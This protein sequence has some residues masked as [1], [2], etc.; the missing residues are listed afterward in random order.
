MKQVIVIGG[1][2]AGMMAAI[3][4]AKEGARVTLLEQNEKTGKKIFITGKGRCNLTNACEQEDFFSHVISN[5]KFLYSAFYQ[6]DNQSVIDFFENAGC[7]LKVERGDRVFPLSDHSSDVIAALNRQMEK[8][9]I[10]VCLHTKVKELLTTVESGNLE[11]AAEDV[12]GAQSQPKELHIMGV[13]LADGR[14][15]NADAVIVATGGKS[16]E[17]TG[18]T[19][20][21]YGFAEG[22]GHTVKEVKPALVPFT[23]K[24]SW[25]M[26]LQ[27][28]SLKNVAITLKS[29]KKKIYEGFGEMLFTHFGV[30]GPLILS[31]SSYYVKKFYGMPVQ[32]LIDLKPALTREQLDKRLLKDFGENKNRQF[33]NALDGLFPSKLIPIMIRLSGI[34][35]EKRVNEITR[36]ERS[37]LIECTKALALTVTGTRDFKEAIITQG[38]VH[39][40]EVNPSTMESKLV[41]GLYFAGEVLDLDAVTGGFN[42][43]IAWS[44]GYLAGVSAAKEVT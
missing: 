34:S 37:H 11:Y 6:M 29:D 20:D 28:L 5:G 8:E 33:K 24:E 42:L 17:T 39:V 30:S 27:G 23:V 44:T 36:E 10:K 40:K 16:Y 1:G 2:A 41:K 4:A 9:G 19:G 38:G 35:P 18:S 26:E 3:G 13:K 32:L 12:N 15:L 22:V 31:A 21:G 43:Q 25:C 14:V 7:R